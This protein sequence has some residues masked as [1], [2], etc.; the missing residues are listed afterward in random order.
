MVGLPADGAAASSWRCS[1][2]TS[3]R[4]AFC[5]VTSRACTA[6]SCH[7]ACVSPRRSERPSGS[8]GR[9]HCDSV[10]FADN[11]PDQRQRRWSGAAGAGALASGSAVGATTAGCGGRREAEKS[12]RAAVTVRPTIAPTTA[13][14]PSTVLRP[15]PDSA[16]PAASGRRHRRSR[17]HPRSG[18]P[19]ARPGTTL[20]APRQDAGPVSAN[21]QAPR[22]HDLVTTDDPLRQLSLTITPL[23]LVAA[24][25][26][27]A[28]GPDGVQGAIRGALMLG[29]QPPRPAPH[30]SERTDGRRSSPGAAPGRNRRQ[31]RAGM[32]CC[33]R[34]GRALAI[35]SALMAGYRAWR[36]R[37]GL[38]LGDIKLAAVVPDSGCPP[39][40]PWS[41]SQPRLRW[42]PISSTPRYGGGRS[43]R[44]H[45]FPS[46]CSW[47]PRSGWA[48]WS[49]RR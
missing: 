33:G 4:P 37:N 9:R 24:S 27:A 14:L 34:P 13:D 32:A 3:L 42:P 20:R 2:R 28:P 41:R 39:C 45:F 15:A 8:S 11:R 21:G 5:K 49:R 35:P 48:G 1:T 6:L 23:V 12:G 47:R 40:S 29:W 26:L 16:A 43:D 31:M 44:P 30:H 22:R 10:A 19:E 17:S 25:L 18:R 7:P 36:G 46:A 38:G